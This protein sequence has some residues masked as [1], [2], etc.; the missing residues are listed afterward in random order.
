LRIIVSGPAAIF[1]AAGVE[2]KSLESLSRFDS[3][4][5]DGKLVVEDAD[6]ALPHF[7]G[8]YC[9]LTLDRDTGALRVNTEFLVHRKLNTSE[10]RLL[11]QCVNAQW[12]DGFGEEHHSIAES[13]E[14]IS[15][16]PI[17]YDETSIRVEQT[18]GSFLARIYSLISRVREF[19]VTSALGGV[20]RPGRWG[21][22]RLMQAAAEG[23]VQTLTYC[24]KKKANVHHRGE[25]GRTSLT[26]AVMSGNLQI[27][28][29]L[30]DAGANPNDADDEGM[31]AVIWAANRGYLTILDGLVTRGA[32]LNAANTRGE[33]ALF[34]AQEMSMVEHLLVLGSD[35]CRRD[36]AGN[37]AAQYARI[38]AEGFKTLKNW[39]RPDRVA[40]EEAKASLL[41]KR[42]A[43][44]I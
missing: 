35:P 31:S 13:G 27:V 21:M 2:V 20:D 34:Y 36:L 17:P 25:G 30:L 6:N 39:P 26:M 5:F 3:Y 38:Q 40:F 29:I 12:S 1:D 22:T 24:I 16:Y 43:E 32:T 14:Q 41:E 4:Q 11:V 37:T 33:T 8:G 42:C 28:K 9:Y 19:I 44:L 18:Q 23:D 15:L 7:K 10:L